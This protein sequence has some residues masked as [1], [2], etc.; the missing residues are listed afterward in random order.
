MAMWGRRDQDESQPTS[1]AKET[2]SMPH[3]ATTAA[4]L[5]GRSMDSTQKAKIGPSIQI[6]GELLGKEDLVIEGHVEGVV[7]LKDHHLTVGRQA[8]IQATSRRSRSGSRG[9]CTAT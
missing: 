9:P 6:K 7:R 5:K 4:P 1:P 3:P 8:K 2:P